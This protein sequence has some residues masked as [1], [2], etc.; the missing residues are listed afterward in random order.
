MSDEVGPG[1]W[2]RRWLRGDRT[3]TSRPRTESGYCATVTP[4]PAARARPTSRSQHGASTRATPGGV[5]PGRFRDADVVAAAG[6]LSDR[7]GDSAAAC[8]MPFVGAVGLAYRQ[9][10]AM[11]APGP[12]PPIRSAA[13]AP[14]PDLPW[15]AVRP[16]ARR[17][18]RR[19][20]DPAVRYLDLPSR[21]AA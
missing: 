5:A 7:D 14:E 12:R 10:L 17:V 15:D 6:R 16:S 8:S 11:A 1:N 4:L 9:S 21:R 18:R 3:S 20:A 19:P 13:S 2:R